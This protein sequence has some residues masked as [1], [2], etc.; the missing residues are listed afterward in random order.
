[1]PVFEYIALSPQGK[2]SKGTIDAE[3]I[4][5]ARQRLRAQGVF[6]TDIKEGMAARKAATRD[7]RK[8]FQ[9]D[10]VST[11]DLAIAT[12]QL[13]T[14]SGAGL[15]LVAAL[16][17]LADQT[18]AV[19]LKR[20]IIDVKEKV[21]EGSSLAKAM[22]NFPK[23]FPKLYINMVASGEASG[24]LDAVLDN[25]ADYLEG[26][27]ELQ[28]KVTSALTYPALMLV[29]CTLVVVV[30][31]VFVVPKIVDIFIKQKIALPV[32][33]RI[34][35]G[36][37]NGIVNWWWLIAAGI[38]GAISLLRWYYR[39]P[40]GRQVIDR[41]IL[42]VPIYGPIFVK[43]NT[44]RVMRTL[45]TLLSSGV[46]LLGALEITRNLVSNVHLVKTLE[47][48]REG[49]QEGRSLAKEFSKSGLFPP[50]VGHMIAIGEK[51]GELESMLGKVGKIYESEVNAVLG[52]ITRI[53]EP[54]MMV[55]VGIVVFS[56]VMSVLMPMTELINMV[57]Q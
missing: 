24:T 23:S 30:L 43:V 15:P 52:G 2:T 25:L 38:F 34:M 48:A 42:S 13:A 6:P 57:Q 53:I 39:Q 40:Q 27:L 29:I 16:A 51:S 10:R 12:R 8:Y 20:V 11:G 3:N 17:A 26:Q 54:L 36:I 4:R 56:I 1:M 32:P 55:G 14:L 18:E 50:M 9:S 41:F 7:I 49:V 31:L 44:A 19:T 45:G 35:L 21:E 33:T 37:S 22:G 28:R 46:G 47:D 5:V